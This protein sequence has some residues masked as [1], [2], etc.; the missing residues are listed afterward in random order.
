MSESRKY[1]LSREVSEKKMRRMAY[2]ILE[3]NINEKEIILAGIRE[4]GSVVARTIQRML[5]EISSVKTELVTLSL[6]KKQPKEVSV[7]PSADFNNKV[8]IVIDDVSNSGKTLLFAL[9]PFL[10][11]HPKKIQT[12]VLVERSHTSFPVR[13]DY[14]GLSIAS[15]IQEHIYVEVEG[16]TITGA[17]LE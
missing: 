7:S 2:E 13:P 10:D 11:T 3:N 12:L 1:I 17:Y 6:D 9:K 4:S 14:V 16:E 8:I 5:A 15:T